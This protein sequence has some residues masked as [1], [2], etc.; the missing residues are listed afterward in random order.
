MPVN[1]YVVMDVLGI[2]VPV[3]PERLVLEARYSWDDGSALGW[4]AFWLADSDHV[5][6]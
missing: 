4:L 1:R 5:M 3:L 6:W 2:N